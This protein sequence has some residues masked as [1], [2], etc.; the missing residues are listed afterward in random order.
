MLSPKAHAFRYAGDAEGLA[1]EARREDVMVG[2]G[3]RFNLA[4]VATLNR[5]EVRFVRL[6]S[7]SVDFGRVHTFA[8]YAGEPDSESTDTGEQVDEREVADRVWPA[9]GKHLKHR[10]LHRRGRADARVGAGQLYWHRKATRFRRV[11]TN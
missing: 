6:P 9:F 10:L 2:N 4:D 3:V 5:A 1:R 11:M 7:E 8:T